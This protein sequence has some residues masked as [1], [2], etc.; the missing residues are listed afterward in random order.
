MKCIVKILGVLYL[1]I[2]LIN[3]PAIASIISSGDVIPT[4]NYTGDADVTGLSS[5]VGVGAEG[6]GSLNIDDGS[7]LTSGGDGGYVGVHDPNAQ[8]TVLVSGANSEWKIIGGG[9]GVGHE[10]T[11]E[12]TITDNARISVETGGNSYIATFAGAVGNVN[13][14]NNSNLIISQHLSIAPG[15]ILDD[16][17]IGIPGVP[18]IGTLNVDSG[19]VVNVASL[20]IAQGQHTDSYGNLNISGGGKVHSSGW[21]NIGGGALNSEGIAIVTGEESEL[22]SDTWVGIGVVGEESPAIGEV[23]LVENGKI[24]TPAIGIGTSGRLFGNGTVAGD[25]NNRGLVS[26]GFST[27][28]LTVDGSFHHR[29][30]GKLEIEIAGDGSD[31]LDVNAGVY[32][33]GGLSVKLVGGFEPEVGR[34]FKIIKAGSV[35][36]EFD[37]NNSTIPHFAGRTFDIVYDYQNS[38]VWLSVTKTNIVAIVE[39]FDE[40]VANNTLEGL[41]PGNSANGRLNAFRNMLE[42]V[43]DLIE[44]DDIEGA[45]RQLRTA[46]EKCDGII[47][48][49]DFVTGEAGPELN[50]MISEL[51]EQLGCY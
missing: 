46:S 39:F 47:P 33:Y 25:I 3:S 7:I 5:W 51:M 4:M 44:I 36:G 42:T 30:V 10:G 26:P 17:G 13:V 8:G 48:P 18:C 28:L 23:Y 43:S 32:L 41:G 49:P 6:T 24:S 31:L 12:L 2:S 14:L 37:L 21:I 19:G 50:N 11:G 38:E 29:D 9:L 45:C 22:S 27:G 15:I 35:E 16:E 34:S 40:S 20:G 1:F